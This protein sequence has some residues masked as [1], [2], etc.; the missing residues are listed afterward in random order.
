MPVHESEPTELDASETSEW[1]TLIGPKVTASGSAR[2]D[3]R[4]TSM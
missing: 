2:I 4:K 3:R 1:A